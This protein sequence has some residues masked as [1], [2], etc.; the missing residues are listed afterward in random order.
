VGRSAGE[1]HRKAA[2]GDLAEARAALEG[3]GSD[4]ELIALARSCLAREA[5]DRPRHA[6]AV[7]QRTTSYRADV[8]EKP[9]TAEI[10]RATEQARAEEEA[11][12]RVLADELAREA[13]ARTEESRRM[14]GVAEAKAKA[15]RRARRLT[16]GLAAAVLG[17]VVLS[18]GAYAWFQ[19]QRA[20]RQAGASS[21]G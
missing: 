5:E 6:G 7:A 4:G 8:Q 21:A 9:R 18:G 14:A 12:R 2:L 16:G 3:S 10:A 1:L 11:K 19:R 17:L 20:E 15:E 13:Q